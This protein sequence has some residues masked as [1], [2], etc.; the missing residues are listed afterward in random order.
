[1]KIFLFI[2]FLSCVA[3]TGLWA[4]KATEGGYTKKKAPRDC[5]VSSFLS[6]LIAWCLWWAWTRV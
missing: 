4:L 3:D 2:I 1:M 6:G 5:W